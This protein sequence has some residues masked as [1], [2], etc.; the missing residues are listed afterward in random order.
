MKYFCNKNDKYKVKYMKKTRVLIK[1]NDNEIKSR[2][3]TAK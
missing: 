1:N 3:I 2:N